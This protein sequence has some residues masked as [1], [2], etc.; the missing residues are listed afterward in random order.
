[1][2]KFLNRAIVRGVFEQE[3]H[4]HKSKSM[5]QDET[6]TAEDFAEKQTQLHTGTDD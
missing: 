6:L 5:C 3:V 2:C 4:G 1:M